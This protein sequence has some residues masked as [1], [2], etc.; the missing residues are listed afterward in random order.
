MSEQRW[1]WEK[2]IKATYFKRESINTVG[3]SAA[4]GK[5]GNYDESVTGWDINASF[6]AGMAWN[7]NSPN[8]KYSDIVLSYTGQT[9]EY[10]R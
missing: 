10:S 7:F 2:Y 5:Y 8:G 6:R 1:R 9:A 3:W 4:T